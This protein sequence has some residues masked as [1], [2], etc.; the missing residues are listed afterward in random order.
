MRQGLI[1][2]IF[3]IYAISCQDCDD[4]DGYVT[5]PRA[6]FTFLDQ[7]SLNLVSEAIQFQITQRQSTNDTLSYFA[8]TLAEH[9]STLNVLQDSIDAGN[10]SYLPI[11][12]EQYELYQY[13]SSLQV[14]YQET[15]LEIN[16]SIDSLNQINSRLNEGVIRLD[17]VYNLLN[18][19]YIVL[20]DSTDIHSI[21]LNYNSNQSAIR[22]RLSNEYFD[23]YL[24]H[25]NEILT[26]NRDQLVVT[27]T[28]IDTISHTFHKVEIDCPSKSCDPNAALFICYY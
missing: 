9:T 19:L 21:P 3:S 27:M 7:D 25:T 13:D 22:F 8:R 28:Q 14:A 10:E 11:W 24:S 15:S 6:R 12:R 2:F 17:T 1:F 4:C 23:I 18:D 26:N 5:E 16:F 20:E